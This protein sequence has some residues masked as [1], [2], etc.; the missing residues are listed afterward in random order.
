MK[1]LLLVLALLLS[2]NSALASDT[3]KLKV[4]GVTRVREI[5][6]I[7]PPDRTAFLRGRVDESSARPL[8]KQLQ[9]F[10]AISNKPIYLLINSPGG[11]VVDGMEIVNTM[12][13]IK[14]L[15]G[16]RITCVIES[17]AFSMAAIIQA[18]CSQTYAQQ[19]SAIMFHQAKYSVQGET[20]QVLSRVL[21][22]TEYLEQINAEVAAQMGIDPAEY[23]QRILVEWWMTA[24]TA[25][26][27][28]LVDGIVKNL[29][30]TP[31]Q[32]TEENV[33]LQ[34]VRDLPN[35]LRRAFH[36]K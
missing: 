10:A 31:P 7:L 1:N 4:D 11:S 14:T 23:R 24:N 12:R 18:F 13:A 36:G 20:A 25:A 3:A 34:V 35:T 16:I 27:I 32:P 17:E 8:I 6:L 9:D 26:S 33:I 5:N 19:N 30:Y 22:I 21:F 2:I 15:L 29:Y 28:G